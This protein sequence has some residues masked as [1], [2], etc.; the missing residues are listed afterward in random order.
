MEEAPAAEE[1]DEL[2]GETVVVANAVVY[3]STGNPCI[4]RF[5]KPV[6]HILGVPSEFLA[7]LS[8]A[9]GGPAG[10]SA[11]SKQPVSAQKLA[12]RSLRRGESAGPRWRHS[13]PEV[14]AAMQLGPSQWQAVPFPSGAAAK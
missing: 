11:R 5:K 2:L 3:D 4:P 7:P 6:G 9:P 14:A 12:H 1:D 13:G 8:D 10:Q